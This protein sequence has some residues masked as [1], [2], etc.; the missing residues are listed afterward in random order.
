VTRALV[1]AAVVLGLVAVVAIAA[2]GSTATGSNEGRLP[3]EWLLDSVF[4][5]FLLQL[6]LAAA[7]LAY[8]LMQ[9]KE[10]ARE[11]ARR[12]YRRLS[13]IG[14]TLFMLAFTLFA[15]FRLRNWNS[16]EFVDELG[17]Q[18]FP[19]RSPNAGAGGAGSETYEPEFTWIPIAIVVGLAVV[20]LAAWYATSRRR[21]PLVRE[22]TALA[23][24]LAAAFDVTLDDLRAEKDP[25]RAVIAAYARL[26]RVLAA[27]ELP[28]DRAEAP[29]EYLGRILPLLEIEPRSVRRL[30]DLFTRAKFSPHEVDASMKDE[31]IDALSTAREELRAVDARREQERLARLEAA[32]GRP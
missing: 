7:V 20:A 6:V 9:R 21:K 27:H 10:I 18:A 14:F 13:F 4:S 17:E 11:A 28:R 2:S 1:P 24:E 5:L 3:A 23:E 16:P 32:A 26:E 30:T 15:Y 12:R 25:R 22:A 31:A 19:E 29:G 8:G